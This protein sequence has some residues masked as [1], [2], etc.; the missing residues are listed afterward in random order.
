ML[1]IGGAGGFGLFAI[2]GGGGLP[3]SAL[4]GRELAGVLAFDEPFVAVDA[5]FFHGAAEPF[6]AAMPGKTDTGLAC[7]SA[8][9]DLGMI[10]AAGATGATGAAGA[11]GADGTTEA[12]FAPARAPGGGGGGGGGGAAAALGFGTNSR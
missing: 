10:F 7:M 11:A 1:P 8:E 2:G 6:A 9:M 4:A 12:R 5:V 3:A